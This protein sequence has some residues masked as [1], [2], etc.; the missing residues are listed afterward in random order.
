M[1]DDYLK[2]LVA[3]DSRSLDDLMT[4]YGQDVWNYAYCIT[5]KRSMADDITQDVFIQAYRHVA[6]FRGESSVK[7]WLLRICRNISYNYRN[8]AFFRKVLLIDSIV[9]KEFNRS[10]EQSFLEK[11]AANEVWK[12]VFHLPKKY[13]EPLMLHAKYQLSLLEIADILK[14]PEGTV[15]SRLFGARKR[16]TI[17]LKEGYYHEIN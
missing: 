1:S 10:A 15:K 3:M 8:T 14:I 12:Q 6:S 2:Y 11:E 9:L 16:L 17:L 5:K 13:R 7:T 4:K